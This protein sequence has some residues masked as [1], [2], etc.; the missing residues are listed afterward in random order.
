MNFEDRILKLLKAYLAQC[1]DLRV[2]IGADGEERERPQITLTCSPGEDPHPQV[3]SGD[4]YVNLQSSTE[5]LRESDQLKSEAI[6]KA[7]N[8]FEAWDRF[9]H[10][11]PAGDR[12]GWDV[13][14]I[15]VFPPTTEL[16]GDG[17]RDYII[18]YSIS[19]VIE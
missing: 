17:A 13:L 1:I 3:W 10:N 5:E 16:D 12:S 14:G 15:A 9:V 18:R 4:I 8:D 2:V 11:R 6:F 7:L 19:A